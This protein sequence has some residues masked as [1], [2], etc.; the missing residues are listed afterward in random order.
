[1]TS[2]RKRFWFACGFE[3]MLLLLAGG[4]SRVLNQPWTG[5]LRWSLEASGWG[6]VA[7]GPLLGWFRLVLRAQRG[8]FAAV[9]EFLEQRVQPFFADWS[10]PEL[11]VL[12]LVAGLSEEVFFRAVLHGGLAPLLGQPFAILAASVAFGLCHPISL[13]YAASTSVVGVYFSGLWL[14]TGNLLA[15]V[16]A[17]AVYDFVALMFLLRRW[18]G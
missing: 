18:P 7:V 15:P 1:M 5:D 3:A 2:H 10:V 8:P 16:L 9:R 6:L 12:S 13:A 17:H 4:L 11:A 14:W